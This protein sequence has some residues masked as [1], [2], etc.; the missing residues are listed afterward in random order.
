MDS[1]AFPLSHAQK[2]LWF[3]QQLEPNVPILVAQYVELRGP[4]NVG[5]L[6]WAS[7]QGSFDIESPGVRIVA[8]AGEPYQLADETIEDELAYV[9]L[10]SCEDPVA[11]AHRWMDER[12]RRPMRVYRDRLISATLLH[13]GL[14]HYF[15]TTFAHHLILDGYGAM[16]LMNRVA[17]L[18]THAVER[19]EAPRSKALSLRELYEAEDAYPDSRRFEIDR[20]YWAERTQDLPEP[21]RLTDRRAAPSAVSLLAGRVM[22]AGVVEKLGALARE[23][24]SFEVP[25]VVAAF[26]AYLARMTGNAEVVL[27][28]PVSA[29]TTAGARRSGGSVAN[30]VPLRIVVDP[31]GS[32]RD[33]VRRVQL[34]LTG[35]LR[36]QRYRYE[37]ILH[38]MRSASRVGR[39]FGPMVN[40][41]MFHTETWWGDVLGELNVLTAGPVDDLA[42]AIYPGAAGRNV[43]VDFEGNPSVYGPGELEGHHERFLDYLG[44]F[45]GAATAAAVG[46]LP[47]LT[48]GEL[49]ALA[50]LT[51]P[52]AA[53]PLT[54]PEIF[55]LT[56]DSGSV[57]LRCGDAEMTYRA[58]HERSNRLARRLLAHGVGVG[59]RVALMLPRSIEQV[60]A[61]WA[62]ARCGAAFVPVDTGYPAERVAHMIDESGV[63][64]AVAAEPE[65]VP[66][67]VEWVDVA[68][69][70]GDGTPLADAELAH[71][72]R[73]DNAAYVIYTSGS[74]GPP[75]GITM[76]HRGLA[77]HAAAVGRLYA[78]TPRSRVLMGA[79][80]SYDAS[81]H[82]LLVAVTAVATLVIAPPAV[83]GGNMLLDLLRRERITHWTTTPAVPAQ[84]DPTGLPDLEVLAVAGDVCPP[85]LVARWGTGRTVLNLYGPTEVTIWATA[86]ESLVPGARTTIGRPIEGVSAVVLD[87]FLQPVPAGVVGELY[88]SGPGVGRGYLERPGVSAT[89]F[90]ADPFTTDL[91]R[92]Y[93]TGDLVRWSPDHEL[94]FVDRADDQVKIRGFRVELGEVT[95]V[96]GRHP[97]VDTAIAVAHDRNGELTVDGY[98]HGAGLDPEEIL[99]G[100]AERLPGYMVPSTVTVLDSVP[101]TPSGKVDRSALPIPAPYEREL[102]YWTRE[103]EGL[104]VG[105]GLPPDHDV[106]VT[107]GTLT[108]VVPLAL[109]RH[110][111]RDLCDLAS[112]RGVPL[113]TVVH[114]A[115]AVWLSVV[116]GEDDLAIGAVL[117]DRPDSVVDPASEPLVLRSRLDPRLT[118][119]EFVMVTDRTERAACAHG[120]VP[121][122][123]VVDAV[124]QQLSPSRH[125]LFQVALAEEGERRLD[126]LDLVVSLNGGG[127]HPE[128]Q[129]RYAAPRFD[130]ST[131]E[132]WGRRLHRLFGMIAED[133]RVALSSIDLLTREERAA[134]LPVPK[135]YE[136]QTKSLPAVFR[137]RVAANPDALAVRCGTETVSYA[138]VDR[139]SAAL[140][141]TL[142]SSGVGDEAIV[143]VGLSNPIDRVVA[144]VA[145]LRSGATCLPLDPDHPI[146]RLRYLLADVVPA[147]L[148][149]SRSDAGDI[150]HGGHPTLVLDDLGEA[151]GGDQGVTLPEWIHPDRTAYVL[152]PVGSAPVALTHANVLAGPRSADDGDRRVRDIWESLAAGTTVACEPAQPAGPDIGSHLYVLD[153]ALRPVPPGTV[154]ELYVGGQ[155]ARGFQRRPAAT[156]ERFVADPFVSERTAGAGGLR[157]YRT[158]DR[159]RYVDGRLERIPGDSDDSGLA[160]WQRA[161]RGVGSSSPVPTDRV[162]GAVAS[163]SDRV[164]EFSIGAD[165]HD[166][167]VRLARE[168]GGTLFTVLRASLAILLARIGVHRDIVIGGE[169]G[170]AGD[171]ANTVALRARITPAMSCLEVLEQVRRFDVAAFQHADVP[172]EAL[173]DLIGG[174]R[175]QVWLALSPT[176]DEDTT[177]M[178]FDLAF[179]YS[180]RWV[181]HEPAGVDGVVTYTPSLF[182]AATVRS[183]AAL[184]VDVLVAVTDRPEIDVGSIGL[185][186]GPALDGGEP[187]APRTLSEILT[188]TARVFPDAPAL[189]DGEVTLTY[190]EL[191]ARSDSLARALIDAGARPGGVIALALPRSI[192][193]MIAL[194]AITKTGAAFVPV[195]PTHPAERLERVLTEADV[196][197]GVGAMS[198]GGSRIEWLPPTAGDNLD[199][200]VPVRVPVHP[201]E[202]AYVIYTSGSTG[203][204]KGVMVP[205]RGVSSLTE[206]AV[207]R[208]RVTSQ[209]RV[210]HA[211]NPTFDAALLETLLAFG[212]GACL[213]VTPAEVYAGPDLHR[214]LVEHRVSHYLSTPAVLT[215]LSTDGLEHIEVVAVGGEALHPD[216]AAVWS[217]GRRMLNAYGPTE[218][219]VVAT[220]ADVDG[221]VTIG[222][223]IRGT[224]GLVLDDRLRRVPIGAV[225]E[226]YLSGAGLGRG[227]VGDPARTAVRFVAG[228][229]GSRLYRTGDL[230]HRRADGNLQF[231]ARVDR[232][233]KI[234]GVRIEPGEVDAVIARVA[235]VDGAITVAR[236]H[237]AGAD[238]LV[239][240]VVPR[241]SLDVELLRKR[242]EDIL[243]SYLV[244]A[245]VVVLE[246]FPLTPSGKIDVKA[247]P[248]PALESRAFRAPESEVQ[249]AVVAVFADVLAVDQVGLDDE[250]F[251]LGG[252]SLIATQAA[253]RLSEAVDAHV[254]VRMIFEASTVEALAEQVS[255]LPGTGTR[256]VLA[257]RPRPDRIPLS[258]AQRRMWFLSRFDPASP[259]YNMPL[260]VRLT[261]ALDVPALQQAVF[262]VL[263]RHESL[264]T[265]F[266]EHDGEPVQSVVP[267][268]RVELD[269]SPA[270]VPEDAVDAHVLAVVAGGF[271]V[272]ASVP[273]RG[274]LLRVSENELVLVVVVHHISADGFSMAPLAR[275]V[276]TAYLARARGESPAWAPLPVQ[277]AD[278]TLWQREVLG[279]EDDPASSAAKQFEYWTRTLAGIPDFLEL[280]TDRPRPAVR[281]NRGA[282]VPVTID[283]ATHRRLGALTQQ[284]NTTLFMV[285]HAALA[286]LLARVTATSDIV[287]GTPVAGRGERVLDDVVGMFVNTLVLRTEVDPD[288]SLVDVLGRVRQTDLD[289]MAHAE[290]PF[291]R[292]VEILNP[293]RSQSHS[294]L[295]QVMLAFQNQ[296]AASLE[297]P[298]LT[299]APL[300]IDAQV[301]KFDLDFS[302][303]D[304]YGENGDPAG[305]S[306]ILTYSADLFDAATAQRFVRGLLRV[307][308]A[309]AA[310]PDVRVCDVSLLTADETVQMRDTWNATDV[311]LRDE[312]L[313]DLLDA[314]VA[315]SPGAVAVV[316]DGGSWTYGELDARVN[317]LA[318]LLVDRG[319]G[320]DSLVALAFERSSD[321]IAGMCA[322]LRAGGGYV[323]L[324]P[325][326]PAERIDDVLHSSAADLVLT[327]AR[328]RAPLPAGTPRIDVDT[329]DL[330]GFDP[331]PVRDTD[332]VRP[333]RPQN[334]AYVLFTSGSTGR[335]KGVV[336][337]HAAIVNQLRWLADEYDVTA[338]DRGML[339][340]PYTFDVSVWEIFLPLTV[341]ARVVVTRPGGHAELDY[342][343]AV[344]RE[345]R[346]TMMHLVPSVLA[347]FLA[348]GE[349]AAL[350]S[351]RHLYVGGEEVSSELVEDALAL[352]PGAF[353]NTYGPTEAAITSTAFTLGASAD[354]R[355]P[356]GAPVWNTRAY[357]LDARL[358]PVPVGVA[359]ELYLGGAQLARGYVGRSELTAERFVADPFGPRG[360][361][362]YR[363]GDRAKWTPAGQ[364]VYLGRTDLQVK[365][366][367]L[368]IELREVES[369][370]EAAD[371]VS[372]AAAALVSDDGGGDRLVGYVV[373]EPGRQIDASALTAS[374][375][376]RLPS[377]MVP[378]QIMVLSEL[379]SGSAGK[380]DRRALP[381][382]RFEPRAFRA[383]ATDTEIVVATA[384][385]ELLGV[386]KVG[387][388]D[389][390]F[391]LGGNSLLAVRLVSALAASTGAAVPLQT[392]MT[393]PTPSS[394]AA[395]MNSADHGG[396]AAL[397]VVLPIRTAG[398]G[399]P[400]FCI[401]PV[402]GLAWCYT[403]LASRVDPDRPIYGL[404]SPAIAE[405]GAQ[406]ASIDDLAAR[407]VA[408]IRRIQAHGPYDLLGWSL[409]GVLAHAVAVRLQDAGDDV[410]TLVMLDSYAHQPQTAQA[411]LPVSVGDLLAGIGVERDVPAAVAEMTPESAVDLLTG[412]G[413]PMAVFTREQLHRLIASAAHNCALLDHHRPGVFR[414]DVAFFTAGRD[415]PTGSAAAATWQ[416]YVAG[417][418]RNRT[419]DSAHWHMTSPKVTRVVGSALRGD[420]RSVATTE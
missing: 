336:V 108:D 283:A 230:V 76:P 258:P 371:G 278:F 113:F 187:C 295:F 266:P 271:D 18:Y 396:D 154:G 275:D 223:P 70:P 332:R 323:P 30:V 25:I 31:H 339:K 359:G 383:P 82:E 304:G 309:F 195:D 184:F 107:S 59:N 60:V 273:I 53:A 291:E 408:E 327:S 404:Q 143:A 368:R 257:P 163:P 109:E 255:S 133:P 317:R 6:K 306:G 310:H 347:A 199:G 269:L 226:L 211:Y 89:R 131:V 378:S 150:P 241:G 124:G 15:L 238:A 51:G 298:G 141:R 264:R 415:D 42:V 122:A 355:V 166:A 366:R 7:E 340:A 391:E 103:L 12:R 182:D 279:D 73:L 373:A 403:G 126:C 249:R 263:E 191:D 98:V 229:G 9:D 270:P 335:P 186:A 320:P 287:I 105:G 69:A 200:V 52:P 56:V 210:L 149:I 193:F 170:L 158:G 116:S 256:A 75:R 412:T 247:L 243:P 227:Y 5:A 155:V 276:A 413:G 20:A 236:P 169:A 88:L 406:P 57:A 228:P 84:M 125:P 281:T 212:S 410:A 177:R 326:H 138:D 345:Y 94:E 217:D 321:M 400:L 80:P 397:G 44:G 357:V 222:G 194:W 164:H 112:E 192:E 19:T 167:A 130:R 290:A 244:P 22:D 333:L 14:D 196:R 272:S 66:A 178:P 171:R 92:M 168:Q 104:P 362:L 285:V 16:V 331:A 34:E 384:F 188:G 209:S 26:A 201:D 62:V 380:L 137:R 115:V 144:H 308:E 218:S 50:P 379:P 181:G 215:T 90:V 385:E 387:A 93:R 2:G 39:G 142:R 49:D 402:V 292:L 174:E 388:D 342:L 127:R 409:G 297:L 324:D 146:E 95:A 293:S 259:A 346:I 250:F 37:D 313:V 161:L 81:I 282:A 305:I 307:V 208:Y 369:A 156:A 129:F 399:R 224:T 159:G 299:I 334:T 135:E 239:S 418:V 123:R 132:R 289:A 160:R 114:A 118:F 365:M 29:R 41:M 180:E 33:L 172:F 85:E 419:V 392:V 173:A 189:T 411:D 337:S 286:V 330:S 302:L 251:A 325:D 319:I 32:T 350:S 296:K 390:F 152:C 203:T 344:I 354:A 206:E 231:I 341:G 153:R 87:R 234:R 393:D 395:R 376:H 314:Q 46:S 220:L 405:D 28:L 202:V 260:A 117:P 322:V 24:N 198:V 265:M 235:D 245:A 86:T 38:D 45:V 119:D 361:R 3:A 27:S 205:H 204:P 318:R 219:T 360:D 389:N 262:D 420:S 71:P 106:A 394:I 183:L 381:R 148:V 351:L 96:L 352:R 185:A 328:T 407:Y 40:I 134:V 253:A 237:V 416:P 338:D 315:R 242:L 157:M 311:A 83:R 348:A 11:E 329:V 232:Q 261:G 128:V 78:A 294:S 301:T 110:L 343:A 99:A 77:N 370:L 54:L 72:I 175:P 136:H 111:Y 221:H 386:G 147:L 145:V 17:E 414:G 284:H 139:R 364:L 21:S 214:V 179:T 100:V 55:D 47:L 353:H 121:F 363:T 65:V 4:V 382:P 120:A 1:R 207:R 248:A 48:P 240:Y 349:G 74:V 280:P 36:H 300:A 10:Q 358:R 268:E 101:L 13:V 43:R 68:D 372:Q 165:R 374:V 274:R 246:V 97:G 377:Y 79:S 91:Q 162:A 58:L 190:R 61:V 267:A 176:S 225:G 401:H 216:L 288:A 367:G 197:I 63:T 417:A 8:H 140:A 316:F 35:A 252:N 398:A 303:S 64:L 151:G 102:R 312:T 277:Y 23:W 67:G 375:R 254:P 213:V 356:I 233:V